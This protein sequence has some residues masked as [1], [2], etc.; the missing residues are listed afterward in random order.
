L[1]FLENSCTATLSCNNPNNEHQFNNLNDTAAQSGGNIEQISKE[2][3]L[4]QTPNLKLCCKAYFCL[5]VPLVLFGFIS[6]IFNDGFVLLLVLSGLNRIGLV[7]GLERFFTVSWRVPCIFNGFVPFHVMKRFI[8]GHVDGLVAGEINPPVDSGLV[9][10]AG[11]NLMV[12]D[13][14]FPVLH[15]PIHFMV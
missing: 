1:T 2:T 3:N 8:F 14:I 6:G 13:V 4:Q 11:P 9:V 15:L 7:D 12:A 5:I 10:K